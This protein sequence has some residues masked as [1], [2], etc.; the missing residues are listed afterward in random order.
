MD[1]STIDITQEDHSEN[2]QNS[3][4]RDELSQSYK[5]KLISTE[6]LPLN[7]KE[8]QIAALVK[9]VSQTAPQKMNK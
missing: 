1:W 6:I 8:D 9:R 2:L 3:N 4:V 5:E 7:Q